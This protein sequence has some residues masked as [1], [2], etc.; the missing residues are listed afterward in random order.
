MEKLKQDFI[1]FSITNQEVDKT[2]KEFYE[3]NNSVIEPHGA[4]GI[5][6]VEKAKLDGLI[7]SLETADPAKFPDKIKEVLNI[8]PNV[9][10]SLSRLDNKEE[11][12]ETID[13]DYEQ[14]KEK[15]K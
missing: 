3:K 7:V 2:I 9:P 11:S 15:L 8:D 4:V 1:S 6:A 10:D 5:S 14:L 13:N 12:F